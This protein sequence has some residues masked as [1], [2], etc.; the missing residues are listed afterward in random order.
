MTNILLSGTIDLSELDA[1][2]VL[3][4]LEFFS[5]APRMISS[6]I[7]PDEDA[8]SLKNQLNEAQDKLSDIVI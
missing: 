3:T 7:S 6:P 5:L 8:I 4:F 1:A 2:E